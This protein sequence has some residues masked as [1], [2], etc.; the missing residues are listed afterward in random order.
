MNLGLDPT[1]V[2]WNDP[3]VEY[4]LK[5]FKMTTTDRDDKLE[6]LMR[7]NNQM[8]SEKEQMAS[9][10]KELEEGCS[11]L[12]AKCG[13][14]IEM[15]NRL[16]DGAGNGVASGN[17]PEDPDAGSKTTPKQRP[18]GGRKSSYNVREF[19]GYPRPKPPARSENGHLRRDHVVHETMTADELACRKCRFTPSR[20]TATYTKTTEYLVDRQWQE[21]AR[22]ITRRY[23]KKCRRQQAARTGGVLPNE[24]YGINVMAQTVTLRCMIDSFERI[25]KIFHMF[26]GVLIPRYLVEL[27][28]DP[29]YPW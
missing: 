12:E 3:S 13:R 16:L 24:H 20:P 9:K 11:H 21:A 25:R 18:E 14:L 10:N 23:C 29:G 8:A 26:H 5:Y 27:N 19:A 1:Q 4:L 17:P 6:S 28:Y 22:V 2:D 15:Y 7:S